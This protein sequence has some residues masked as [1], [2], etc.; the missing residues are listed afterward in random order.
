MQHSQLAHVEYKL[1]PPSAYKYYNSVQKQLRNNRS[2]RSFAKGTALFLLFIVPKIQTSYRNVDC[3]Q[4]RSQMKLGVRPP[5]RQDVEASAV[6]LL[7][8]SSSITGYN[9]STGYQFEPGPSITHP[10][11]FSL[12]TNVTKELPLAALP[13][14]PVDSPH[15]E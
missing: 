8:W 10:C 12:F 1:P 5:F 3:C 11:I 7:S 14:R 6:Q 2:V 9:K 4:Q 15:A 13:V